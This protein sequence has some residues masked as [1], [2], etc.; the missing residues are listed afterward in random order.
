MTHTITLGTP[1]SF[2]EAL[3]YLEEG[4][5]VGIRPK[6]NSGFLVLNK[7]HWAKRYHL[8]WHRS[9]NNEGANNE[10][11]VEHYLGEWSPVVLDNRRLPL[12]IKNSLLLENITG[13][14]D[15]LTYE[16]N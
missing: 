15:G 2:L 11:P 4:K 13:V 9:K 10:I 8:A 6:G 3:K 14:L 7:P 12:E 1:M 16:K 5:C